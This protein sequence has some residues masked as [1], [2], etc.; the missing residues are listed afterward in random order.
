M[1]FCS[2]PVRKMGPL[3]E[4]DSTPIQLGLLKRVLPEIQ[5]TDAGKIIQIVFEKIHHGP[6]NNYIFYPSII[7][8]VS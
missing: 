2:I 7:S 4:L 1:R 8:F 3:P 5:I 6:C